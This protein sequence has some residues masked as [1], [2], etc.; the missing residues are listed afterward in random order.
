MQCPVCTGKLRAVEKIGVEVDICPECKGV[1]LDRGELEKIIDLVGRGGP[2]GFSK[3]AAASE[4]RPEERGRFHEGDHDRAHHDD[5]HRGKHHDDDHGRH[6][7]EHGSGHDSRY[8]KHRRKGG[9]F[10]QIF[11]GLGGGDD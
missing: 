10:G 4:P 3:P 8:G 5:D 1:W 11:E 9:W 6:S 7:G 2:E